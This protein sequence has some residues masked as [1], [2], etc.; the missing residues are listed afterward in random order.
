MHR[1]NTWKRPE[2][3]TA[4]AGGTRKRQCCHREL[5]VSHLPGP[6]QLNPARA[7]ACLQT[8]RNRGHLPHQQAQGYRSLGPHSG[9]VSVHS[10]NQ[11]STSRAGES[12]PGSGLQIQHPQDNL[13]KHQALYPVVGSALSS[14]SLSLPAQLRP[15]ALQQTRHLVAPYPASTPHSPTS[16]CDNRQQ[17]S[18]R[19]HRQLQAAQQLRSLQAHWLVR[20]L[21]LLDLVTQRLPRGL[22][23]SLQ[24]TRAL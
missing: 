1:R 5:S 13:L 9:W 14:P 4:T 2:Q 18:S 10:T 21:R 7:L 19:P 24:V 15:R 12:S 17:A 8:Q 22:S 16:G 3:S 23:Q 20:A 6:A 11:S